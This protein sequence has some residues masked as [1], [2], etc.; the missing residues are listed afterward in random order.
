MLDILHTESSTGWGGQEART[1]LEAEHLTRRGHRVRIAGPPESGIGR[2]ARRRGLPFHPLPIRSVLDLPAF[3]R[4]LR[5]LRRDRPLI[6]HTHSSKDSWLAGLAGRRAGVPV[7]FRTR[8][9]SIPVRAH[10]LNPVYRLPDRIL[11]TA[12][13]TRDHLVRRCG[14]PPERVI[15]LPTGV[16]LERFDPRVPE[17]GASGRGPSGREPAG[18]AFREEFGL[19]PET[20]A[21]GIVAQL[22][23]SKGHDTFIEAA[24]S[25]SGRR[26]EARFFIVGDGLWRDL[27]AEKVRAEGM[28][29]RVI[30]T[31]YREDVPEILAG[32]DVVV[33]ASTRT[34]GIPQAGL[35]ALATGVPVVGTNVGGIPEIVRDDETG[36]LIEPGDPRALAGAV[37]TLLSDPARRDRM[38]RTGARMVRE[39]FS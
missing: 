31:G 10:R 17:G 29:G 27:V 28:G 8:H 7:L 21:V 30:L 18:R 4:L 37:E 1:V 3:V 38:G 20:P 12:A 22:R 39:R 16:D 33:I 5:L 35:Q 34:D 23:G 26:P 9:V 13:A 15:I 6:L 11:V 14:L 24:R 2:E 36:I 25:L 32:L 19:G